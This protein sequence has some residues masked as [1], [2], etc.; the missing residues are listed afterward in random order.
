MAFTRK[1]YY[2]IFGITAV[3]VI[4]GVLIYVFRC[5]LFPSLTS[6]VPDPNLTNDPIPL[7]SPTPKW[8]PEVPPYNVGMFG[9]KIKALQTVVGIPAD[10]KFGTQTKGAITAKGY[11]VPLSASDY[12]TIINSGG[13]SAASN[14]KGVYAKY[15]NTVVRDKNLN[16]K[17][18]VAKDTW[19]GQNVTDTTTISSVT[20]YEIDGIDYVIKSSTYLKA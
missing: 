14:I 4:A 18:K 8:I 2:W 5:K 20:Y 12:N 15:D 17:R 16:E 11:A 9:P 3:V 6:C 1:T 7:G 13:G 10:G 19:I